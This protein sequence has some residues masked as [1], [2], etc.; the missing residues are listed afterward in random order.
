MGPLLYSVGWTRC[1][2]ED[3]MPCVDDVTGSILD[4]CTL[5]RNF[6]NVSESQNGRAIKITKATK[7]NESWTTFLV[8][9]HGVLLWGFQR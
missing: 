9:V 2:R 6:H 1:K 8:K 4:T 3:K 5:N 7:V